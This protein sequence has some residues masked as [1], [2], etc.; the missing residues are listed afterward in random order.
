MKQAAYEKINANGRVPAIEDPNT[1]IT[2]WESG[3]IFEYLVTK[4]DEKSEISFPP[5]SPEFYHAIQ[6]LHFQRSGQGPHFGQAVWFRIHHKEQLQIAV[7]RYVNEIRPMRILYLSLI[8]GGSRGAALTGNE[9]VPWVAG[10]AIDLE[11]DFPNVYAWPNRLKS[12]PSVITGLG[13]ES[14]A[15]KK[16]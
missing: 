8:Y 13:A 16:L 7:E 4:Y 12:R 10:D 1:G 2:L 9:V 5:N 6:Y 11:E 14:E 3:A 15:L